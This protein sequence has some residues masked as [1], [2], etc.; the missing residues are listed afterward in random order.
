M[1]EKEVKTVDVEI[2]SDFADEAI[3]EKVEEVLPEEQIVE[4]APVEEKKEA[5]KPK[6]ERPKSFVYDDP[7]LQG[8]ESARLAF[9]KAYKKSNNIKWIVTGIV[10]VAII[11]GWLLP[12][13]LIKDE[14]MK[15][16]P[17]YITLGIVAASVVALGIY[18]YL[19]RKKLDVKIKDY[20]HRYYDLS[21]DYVFDGLAITDLSGNIDSKITPAEFAECGL[22]KDIYKVGSRASLTFKCNGRKCAIVDVAGQVK[23]KKALRTVFVGK[24]FRS[25]NTYKGTAAYVYLKGNSRAL[26]P[27][28]L[29][30][31]PIVSETE[32]MIVR[33]EVGAKKA[34]TKKVKDAIAKFQTN[35]LLVDVAI[36]IEEGKTFVALGYE[37]TLMVLPMEN[38]FDPKPTMDFRK[39]LRKVIALVDVIG[40]TGAK[41][42]DDSIEEEDIPALEEIKEVKAEV[43]D[44][45]EDVTIPQDEAEIK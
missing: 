23:D 43:L 6:V 33:G 12:S 13:T 28:A 17:L 45:V 9:K 39:D 1:K 8:I 11:L 40:V 44:T 30:D 32:K 3:K 19:S 26:P 7:R 36:T 21:N 31:L 29:D 20:F 42:D 15:N 24:Y 18:S 35:D 14:N 4:A 34:L 22:Y 16:V 2:E 25:S 10:L 27:T 41:K 37:D 38:A 5:P